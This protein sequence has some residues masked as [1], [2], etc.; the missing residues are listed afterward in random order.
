M[1]DISQIDIYRV[2]GGNLTLVGNTTPNGP[3]GMSGL[4]TRG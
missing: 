1:G 4:A 3:A 2:S